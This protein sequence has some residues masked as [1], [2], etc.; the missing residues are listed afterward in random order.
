MNT[1]KHNNQPSVQPQRR[2]NLSIKPRPIPYS[3]R[4]DIHF[5]PRPRARIKEMDNF[6]KPLRRYT[7]LTPFW[8][9]VSTGVNRA[10]NEQRV[11]PLRRLL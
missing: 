7:W 9:S 10:R 6:I 8:F 2:F 1:P 11:L 5:D 3:S 4:A